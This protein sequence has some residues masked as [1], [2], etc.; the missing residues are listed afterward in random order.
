MYRY[1]RNFIAV[2]LIGFITSTGLEAQHYTDFEFYDTA[3]ANTRRTMQNN[4]NAVFRQI[5]ESHFN[6][7][8]SIN[9]SRTNATQDAI[10]NIRSLWNTSQFY[11]QVPDLMRPI[12][13]M[14]NGGWQVRNI[15]VF[16]VAGATPEER[17]LGIVMEFTAAGLINDIYIALPEHQ[18][19][20]FFRGATGVTDLRRR[21]L[22]VDFVENF[23][24]AYNRKDLPLIE[25][26]FS[27]DALIITGK[28]VRSHG[29]S[30][31]P[32]GVSVE[33][34][35]HNKATYIEGLRRV[36]QR[37]AW[38]NINFEEIE[39]MMHPGNPN[40]YGVTLKQHWNAS[41][42]SDVG[43]LFL[44]IDFRDENNPLIWVRTWQPPEVPKN[45]VFGLDNFRI[46]R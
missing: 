29:D 11:C 1:F 12:L 36:F 28:V 6:G 24:T 17:N 19:E 21:Q 43:W 26:V 23:R 30:P 34:V 22:I 39:V 10:D 5:H 15:P 35:T 14:P 37:N 16:F 3:P 9:L 44:M 45:D 32:M 13:R 42:Y 25:Q 46:N 40:V 27:N 33:Y 4:A 38:L 41:N 7:R 8:Q 31:N 20:D 18:Y 2:A